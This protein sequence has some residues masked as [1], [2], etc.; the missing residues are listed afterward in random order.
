[1]KQKY[2]NISKK[3]VIA[4]LPFGTSYLYEFGFSA[5]TEIKSKKRERLLNIDEELRVCLSEL[6]PRFEE[7]CKNKQAH[8]SH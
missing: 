6:E 8:I 5:L 2:F 3:A 1:M 4:L 7:I